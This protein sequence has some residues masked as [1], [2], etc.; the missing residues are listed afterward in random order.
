MNSR[1][2]SV[3]AETFEW[4]EQTAHNAASD[5]TYHDEIAALAYKLWQERGA[6]IGSDKEDWFRAEDEL[7]NQK[8]S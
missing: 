2:T 8:R 6:P 4:L 3:I 1:K 7:K 5:P